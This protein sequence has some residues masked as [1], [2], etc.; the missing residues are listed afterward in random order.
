M[1]DSNIIQF[2]PDDRRPITIKRR[3]GICHHNHVMLN[4]QTRMVECEDCDQII[5]PYDYMYGWACGDRH[6]SSLRKQLRKEIKK[7]SVKFEALKREERNIKARIR[8]VK[9]G[10]TP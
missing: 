4:E 1:N 8:R 9:K 10:E 2:K 7:L 5:D 3:K 6:L